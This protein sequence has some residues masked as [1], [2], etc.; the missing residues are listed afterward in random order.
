M[1]AAHT[2]S[3]SKAAR[4]SQRIQ[5]GKARPISDEKGQVKGPNGLP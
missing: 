3:I 4:N 5:G 2:G 1:N